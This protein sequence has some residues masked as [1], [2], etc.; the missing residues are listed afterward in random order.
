MKSKVSRDKGS[1]EMRTKLLICATLL[2]IITMIAV[3]GQRSVIADLDRW[4]ALAASHPAFAGQGT[5]NQESEASGFHWNRVMAPGSTIEI[6]G[7]NGNITA[8]GTTGAQVEVTAVKRWRKSDP[9]QV[10]LHV[11]ENANVVTICAL[12]PDQDGNRRAT[13]RE[14]G[15]NVRAND[16][17]VWFTV[18][19][20]AAVSFDGHTIN[21]E[22]IARALASNV[23]AHTVNGNVA[24]STSGYAEAGTVNGNIA[25]AMS[26]AD[27]TDT[28]AFKTVNG[29]MTVELPSSLSARVKAKTV[30]GDI[31]S[32]FPLT[33]T[34]RF[35]GRHIDGT[36]GAGERELNLTTVNGNIKLLRGGRTGL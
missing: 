28:L 31:F 36:V 9:A 34:G 3:A 29:N 12:Y 19:V 14:R 10:E 6:R 5:E 21:G 18:R 15:G 4:S 22:V 25:V 2:A 13:C 11:E 30:S 8:E 32:D 20:P 17:S 1:V 27:W 23:R 7:L 16:V 33:V 26:R 35:V 24:V